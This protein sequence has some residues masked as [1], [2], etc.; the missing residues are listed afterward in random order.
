MDQAGIAKRRVSIFEF[1]L[2]WPRG[3]HRSAA[4]QYLAF[5]ILHPLHLPQKA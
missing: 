1:P 3:G 4:E 5:T 2:R